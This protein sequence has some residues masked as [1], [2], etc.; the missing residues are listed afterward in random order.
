MLK[1]VGLVGPIAAG[2]ATVLEELEKI[3][4]KAFFLGERTREEA[5][6][7][8]LPHDRSVLQN[9]GNDLR[10]KFGDNILVKQT[11]QLFDGSETKIA[12]DGIRNPGEISYLRDK[13]NARIIGVNARV[14]TR[15]KFSKKRQDDADPKTLEE[16]KRVEQID[17]GAGEDIHGQQVNACLVLCDIVIENNGT[18]QEFKKKIQT[19]LTQLDL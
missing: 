4:F 6:R 8:G 2:K 19:A 15:R 16:F 13:Y 10:E 12:I 18:I 5:D 17:R 7:R 3:G 11:E 9:M 14:E 1:V